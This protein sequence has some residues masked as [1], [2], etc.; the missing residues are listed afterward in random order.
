MIVMIYY[1]SIPLQ[2]VAYA[3]IATCV[4]KSFGLPWGI[5]ITRGD[6]HA[7]SSLAM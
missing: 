2:L 6:C 7:R 4:R 3:S 5:R 1:D